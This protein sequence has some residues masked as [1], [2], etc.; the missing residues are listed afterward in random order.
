MENFDYAQDVI[1]SG[2]RW[3]EAEPNGVEGSLVIPE[4]LRLRKSSL[5]ADLLRSE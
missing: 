3:S 2:V 1:L 5:R 4:I